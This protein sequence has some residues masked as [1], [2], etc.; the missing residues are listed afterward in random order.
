MKSSIRERTIIR[1]FAIL[2]GHLPA[3]T[4]STIA[5]NIERVA[6]SL[7]CTT[8]EASTS[9]SCVRALIDPSIQPPRHVS[10]H[11][12]IRFLALL[13]THV[14]DSEWHV[15]VRTAADFAELLGVSEADAIKV[16][17]YAQ[18]LAAHGDLYAMALHEMPWDIPPRSTH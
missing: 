2:A 12:L 17:V 8:E 11:L 5:Y 9:L 18:G 13:A 15:M 10:T 3:E 14:T 16:I 1:F 6:H 7:G 4:W